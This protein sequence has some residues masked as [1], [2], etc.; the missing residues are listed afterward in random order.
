M[1]HLNTSAS[2]VSDDEIVADLFRL[3]RTEQF[4]RA[5]DLLA[6]GQSMH[7]KES[8]DRIKSCMQRLGD[9]L[10]DTDHGDYATEYKLDRS[11]R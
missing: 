6:A 7:P 9:I 11:R 4:R 5:S 1:H 2:V 10:W 8:E 3:A